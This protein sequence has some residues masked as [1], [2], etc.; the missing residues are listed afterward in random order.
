MDIL[1]Y[2]DNCDYSFCYH[3][4]RVAANLFGTKIVYFTIFFSVKFQKLVAS[5]LKD[6]TDF[7]RDLPS[8]K[9]TNNCNGICFVIDFNP[10]WCIESLTVTEG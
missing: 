1:T 2:L 7:L 5:V 10:K 3:V 8:F 6:C 4:T 9:I